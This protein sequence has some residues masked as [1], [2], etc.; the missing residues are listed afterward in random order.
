MTIIRLPYVRQSSPASNC[1]DDNVLI[2]CIMYRVAKKLYISG[3]Q[4]AVATNNSLSRTSF[5]F[6]VPA[7]ICMHVCQK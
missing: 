1:A 7:L 4:N 3:K 2:G 5:A 6:L